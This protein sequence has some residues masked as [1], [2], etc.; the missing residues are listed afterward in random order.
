MNSKYGTKSI[1]IKS[2]KLIDII[3]TIIS[4]NA[5]VSLYIDRGDFNQEI[6]HGMAWQIPDNYDDRKF[7]RIFGSVADDISESDTIRILI[8]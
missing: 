3:D 8:K 7:V 4:H 5:I 2:F 6:W 1:V